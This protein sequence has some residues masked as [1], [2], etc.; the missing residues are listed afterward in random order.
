MWIKEGCEIIEGE[1]I[2]VWL[3]YTVYHKFILVTKFFI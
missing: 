3:Y 1:L 2:E